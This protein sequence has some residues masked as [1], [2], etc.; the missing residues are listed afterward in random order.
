MNETN[1]GAYTYFTP[2]DL[3]IVKHNIPNR[4]V[5]IVVEK[6]SRNVKNVETGAI[7]T[8]FIGIK[9]RWFD[10]N[11]ALQEAVFNT[12]DIKLAE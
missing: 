7:E 10:N 9:C 2:G 5:M 1:L 6:V 3:V 11:M 8:I 4:P 12:K